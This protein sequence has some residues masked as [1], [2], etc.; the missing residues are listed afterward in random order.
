MA[1]RDRATTGLRR[2]RRESR[3]MMICGKHMP[4]TTSGTADG[5]VIWNTTGETGYL[6]LPSR[7]HSAVLGIALILANLI[8]AQLLAS[9]HSSR[10]FSWRI[11]QLYYPHPRSSRY[12]YESWSDLTATRQVS[13]LI[14]YL[15]YFSEEPRQ[16]VHH[17]DLRTF[18]S[19]PS[20]GRRAD[21][22]MIIG[23]RF[24]TTSVACRPD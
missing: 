21:C 4:T 6:K 14:S 10:A 9:L 7:P 13:S 23:D 20:S 12:Y 8:S 19:M 18:P 24:V 1:G 5:R 3:G 17:L 16:Q 2:A 11:I 15:G 22:V